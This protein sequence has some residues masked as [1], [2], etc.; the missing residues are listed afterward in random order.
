[1]LMTTPSL[2]RATV[3][4]AAAFA[5]LSTAHAADPLRVYMIGNSLTDEVKYDAWTSLVQASGAQTVVA[6]KMIPG[7]PLGW[8]QSHPTDGFL[9]PPYGHPEAAF[10]AHPWDALTLQPF[11]SGEADSALYYANLLWEKNPTARVFVYAQWPSKGQGTDWPSAW[12]KTLNEQYT[13][14]LA[15]LRES[16]RGS[17]VHLIPAGHA[18]ARLH[19]K[20]ALGLVPGITSAWDLYSDGVHVN[21]IA[22]YLVG[23]TFY[24]TLFQKS[25]VGLP[26]GDY[27]GKTGSDAD[28]FPISPE[29]ARIIQETVWETVTATPEAGVRTDLP[30]ALTLPGILPFIEKEPGTFV[31]DAAHGRPPYTFAV[32]SGKLPVG[33]ALASDGTLSGTPAAKGSSSFSVRVTDSAGKSSTRDYTLATAP[34]T[35]PRIT[36]LSIPPLRQGSYLDLPLAAP[37]GNGAATWSVTG[38]TFPSG[39][40]LS[41]HGRITGSPAI[42]GDYTFTLS[43][44]DADP[45]SPE[46]ATHNYKGRIAPADTART[47]LVRRAASAPQL[48]GT[49]SKEENWQ[50]SQ[51]LTRP[52]LGR[53]DNQVRFDAQWHGDKLYLAVIVKD[54]TVIAE[55]GWGRPR[56]AV[57]SLVLY[58]DGLNNR[59]A[60]YN[61][62]DRRLAYSPVEQG[63][64]DRAFNIGPF[65]PAEVKSAR[66]A[67]GYV[68]EFSVELSR[69]G[70][71]EQISDPK[72]RDRAY[73]G[74]VFGF[75]LENRD[76]DAPDAPQTSI[77]WNGT[78]KNAEDPSRLGTL[79]LLE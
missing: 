29:L 10:P 25:P 76:L 54:A 19:K 72:Q 66:T 18:I 28:Y 11:R 13:P 33:L 30:P 69:I 50:L 5:A 24:S 6:R 64:E 58:I 4:L 38:G 3:T 2:L 73:V 45:A 36:T 7:S 39:L 53:T 71:P 67:D 42:T 16:P 20:A 31:F 23:L 56:H 15:A 9:T 74:A 21:N 35:A 65:M 68:M 8:H 27:Q 1:M 77:G 78:P 43:V 49:L 79:I 17:Q 55:N 34:D 46:T 60:T 26:V 57:D 51:T 41:P 62:D 70:V 40:I 52:Y 12:Q 22:S 37:G 47:L 48:D 63:P 14:V 59:E 61:F 32:A 75:D 44:R